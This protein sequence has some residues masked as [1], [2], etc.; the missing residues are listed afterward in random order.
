MEEQPAEGGDIDLAP[1]GVAPY[2]ADTK[3]SEKEQKKQ[4]KEAEKRAEKERKE[5]EKRAKEAEKR[6]KE[7]EKALL[8]QAG[9]AS[10]ATN[11]PVASSK[12]RQQPQQQRPSGRNMQ[13][14]RVFLLD[15]TKSTFEVDV[16]TNH[17]AGVVGKYYNVSLN[18]S[19]N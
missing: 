10:P 2:V 16:S 13:K 17:I 11:T 5:A 7:E 6:R 1:V 12:A 14:A 15:G 8:K 9:S 19:H 3:L 4:A 18:T